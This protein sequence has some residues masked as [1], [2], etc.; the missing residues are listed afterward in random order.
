MKGRCYVKWMEEEVGVFFVEKVGKLQLRL[1]LD[2][3]LANLHLLPPFAVGLAG[4]KAR[5]YGHVCG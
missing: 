3:R 2:G 5:G 1:I 4:G